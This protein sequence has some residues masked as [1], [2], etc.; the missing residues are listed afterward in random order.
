MFRRGGGG[1]VHLDSSYVL[2]PFNICLVLGCQMCFTWGI[3]FS[4]KT[5]AGQSVMENSG[6]L[7]YKLNLFRDHACI[8]ESGCHS[9]QT[10]LLCE[11]VYNSK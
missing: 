7:R 11:W 10:L 2:S 5:A 3:M 6:A 4:G 8:S 1:A 9:Y